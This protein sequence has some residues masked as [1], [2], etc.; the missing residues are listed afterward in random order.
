MMSCLS[1]CCLNLNALSTQSSYD[2]S[3]CSVDC[4]CEAGSDDITGNGEKMVSGSERVAT[5]CHQGHSA[6]TARPGQLWLRKNKLTVY[7][8]P[9]PPH[10]NRGFRGHDPRDRDGSSI[11]GQRGMVIPDRRLSRQITLANVISASAKVQGTLKTPIEEDENEARW[12]RV[13][14]VVSSTSMLRRNSLDQAHKTACNAFSESI[15]MRLK[16]MGRMASQARIQRDYDDGDEQQ[17]VDSKAEPPKARPVLRRRLSVRNR[18]E[19]LRGGPWDKMPRMLQLFDCPALG[20]AS[21]P[22]RRILNTRFKT[23]G[24]A[25]LLFRAHARRVFMLIQWMAAF[26]GPNQKR[27]EMQTF[28]DIAHEME[29]VSA[30]KHREEATGILFNPNHYKANKEIVISPEVKKLLT[31]A[32]NCRTNDMVQRIVHSL[33]A[34]SSFSEYPLHMQ[35][36]LGRVAWYEE[37]AAKRLI[38]REGHHAEN[39][40]FILSGQALV[41]KI[42]KDKRGRL[43]MNVMGRLSKGESFGEI[44]LLYRLRRTASVESVSNMTLIVIR[45]EDFKDIF[46]NAKNGE[47][48]HVT[49]LRGIK[50]LERWPIDTLKESPEMT[51]FHFFRRGHVIVPDS[52]TNEWLYI[53]MTGTCHVMKALEAVTP[54]RTPKRRIRPV[55]LCNMACPEYASKVDCGRSK[56][57]NFDVLRFCGNDTKSAAPHEECETDDETDA[58]PINLR[59]I[60]CG[61]AKCVPVIAID[62]PDEPPKPRRPV[63]AGNTKPEISYVNLRTLRPTDVFG[64]E[65]VD[66]EEDNTL[67]VPRTSVL[68]VSNGAELVML[69]RDFFM[70]NADEMVQKGIRANVW[71]YPDDA[72]LQASRLF[73]NLQRHVNW[74][75]YRE[76]LVDDIVQH[77]LY[78]RHMIKR[79][80]IL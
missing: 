5:V 1:K 54:I 75:Q 33:Q 77:N 67:V 43:T 62:R 69:K 12:T 36:K 51:L 31:L 47:P 18:L 79:V 4:S 38:L 35:E 17:G 45:G 10:P 76:E 55:L 26:N 6:A 60:T 7:H 59:P 20:G 25:R 40:Y 30:M 19:M 63:N 57:A 37:V 53:V 24:Q 42:V 14:N 9:Y 21:R 71:P 11:A 64:L 32:S 52:A 78:T 70:K 3:S 13:R 34:M 2:V 65:E 50:F 49:F 56:S 66:F 27:K 74:N 58:P 68:L 28:M 48:E 15:K 16:R 41:K 46:I 73:E 44:A 29:H 72:T 23:D 39:F 80:L 61:V 8:H 22:K